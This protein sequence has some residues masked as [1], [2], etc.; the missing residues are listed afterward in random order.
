MLSLRSIYCFTGDVSYSFVAVAALQI[1][2]TSTETKTLCKTIAATVA[3]TV[4]ET[5]AVMRPIS[6][7]SS[8]VLN[9]ERSLLTFVTT[10]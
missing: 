10:S 6:V 8:H 7:T 1:F 3:L 9:E 5:V 2:L 4:A